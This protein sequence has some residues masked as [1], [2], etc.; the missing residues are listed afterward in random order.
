MF[1][2][3][4]QSEVAQPAKHLMRISSVP[5]KRLPTGLRATLLSF[6]SHPLKLAGFRLTLAPSIFIHFL[7]APSAIELDGVS[8]SSTRSRP[9]VG[10]ARPRRSSRRPDDGGG[11][12]GCLAR[13]TR[14]ARL[15][16]GAAGS[17]GARHWLTR[18][19]ACREGAPDGSRRADIAAGRPTRAAR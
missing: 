8:R 12:S 10:L 9:S 1:F 16:C 5:F 15:H 2:H 13:V 17:G 18:P 19:A 11:H 4:V 14:A 6:W 3:I 7:S